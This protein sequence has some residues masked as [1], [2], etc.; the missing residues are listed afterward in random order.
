MALSIFTT[1]DKAILYGC[2][3]P[4][5]ITN[6]WSQAASSAADKAVWCA[7]DRQWVQP[8]TSRPEVYFQQLI[9]YQMTVRE[10]GRHRWGVRGDRRGALIGSESREARRHGEGVWKGRTD[11]AVRREGVQIGR[12]KKTRWNYPPIPA[13]RMSY[14]CWSITSGSLDE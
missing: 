11:N 13:L 8:A 7:S 4:D 9:G 6:D 2:L 10:G 1:C 5:S 12:L 3:T 14:M